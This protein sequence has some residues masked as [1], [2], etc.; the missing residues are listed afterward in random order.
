M[1]YPYY[2]GYQPYYQP[3]MADQL[4]QLRQQQFHPAQQAQ[5]PPAPPPQPASSGII[6]V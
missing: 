2:G 5:M 1:P 3:P 6:W 4:S